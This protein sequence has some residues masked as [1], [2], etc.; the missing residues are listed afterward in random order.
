M[1]KTQE[2][3]SLPGFFAL[4][5]LFLQHFGSTGLAPE[6]AL[7]NCPQ[8]NGDCHSLKK[9]LPPPFSNHAFRKEERGNQEKCG[10]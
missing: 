7:G 2:T 8:K 9:I 10:N 1:L 6:S 5:A 4:T 3:D